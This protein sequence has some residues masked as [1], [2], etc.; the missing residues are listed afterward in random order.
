MPLNEVLGIWC[1]V[2]LTLFIFTFLYKDNPFY[3][4]AEH[5]YVGVSAAYW[6]V[7]LYWNSIKPKVI[8]GIVP[9]PGLDRHLI[10]IIPAILG[11]FVILRLVPSLT[12]LSRIT[13]AFIIGA[14]S[15]IYIPQVISAIFLPQLTATL[16]PINKDGFKLAETPPNLWAEIWA[17]LSAPSPAQIILLAGV[18][19]VVFFFFFSVEHKGVVGN[20]SVVGI[21][22]IMISF[23][24]QFGY[25][26]MARIS[27]LIG[28]MQY[29]MQIGNTR[30]VFYASTVLFVLVIVFIILYEVLAARR[31]ATPE[32]GEGA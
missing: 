4:F 16:N 24:A 21:Y 9:P 32:P 11:F 15:G 22:F 7:I 31:P 1:G 23:G 12:W 10:V 2:G 13:F 3:R 5:L 28:R 14:G 26:V 30:K 27:L 20:I 6:M 8:D 25:T 29:L 17:W 18:F 19:S